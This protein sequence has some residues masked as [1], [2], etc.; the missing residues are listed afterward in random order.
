MLDLLAFFPFLA[1]VGLEAFEA[2]CFIGPSI[3]LVF[4]LYIL[5]ILIIERR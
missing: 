4:A 1:L 2:G 5:I 3:R